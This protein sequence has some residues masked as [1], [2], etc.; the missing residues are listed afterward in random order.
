MNRG[1]KGEIV[2]LSKFCPLAVPL[3]PKAQAQIREPP[4][5]ETNDHHVV[6]FTAR[7]GQFFI[8]HELNRLLYYVGFEVL[9]EMCFLTA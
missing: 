4:K 9:T 5:R 7:T 6:K 2:V 3:I 8:K 1:G